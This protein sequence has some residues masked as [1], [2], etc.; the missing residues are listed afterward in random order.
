MFSTE[1]RNS[2]GGPL[3]ELGLVAVDEGRA[4]LTDVGAAFAAASVPAIDD[5]TGM[6]LLNEEHMQILAQAITNMPGE[7]A[8]IE[9][10]LGAIERASG[11]QDEVDKELAQVHEDWSEAQVVSHRAA[12]VGRLRDI[13][14][15]EV[16]ALPSAKSE[17]VGGENFSSFTQ[18]LNQA[19]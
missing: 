11:S 18:L 1:A 13:R 14:V 12:M 6:E 16:R 8:E 5:R 2:F 9:L 3:L 19:A 7:R 17:I 15:I 10:F 4:F